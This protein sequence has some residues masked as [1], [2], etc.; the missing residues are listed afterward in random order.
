MSH[1]SMVLVLSPR[2]GEK[3]VKPLSEFCVNGI[4]ANVLSVA[5]LFFCGQMRNLINDI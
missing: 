3:G 2:V 4:C 1:S 5:T